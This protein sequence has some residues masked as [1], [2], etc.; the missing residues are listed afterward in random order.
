MNNN[1]DF[2]LFLRY[3]PDF[4]I[5]YKVILIFLFQLLIFISIMI[6]FWW[7]SS[8]YLLGA[9]LGEF[10]I[11]FPGTLPYR[12]MFKNSNSIR[13]K[14]LKKYDKLAGQAFWYHYES[15]T[16]PMISAAFYLPLLLKTDY[17]LPAII[18]LPAHV[19]TNTLFPAFVALPIGIFFVI[20]GFIIRSASK[21][22]GWDEDHYLYMI[23]PDEGKLI[24]EGIYQYI[25]HP[26]F[27]SRLIIGIGFGFIANNILAFGV[28][29]VHFF[30]FYTMLKSEDE[31]L[32]K[33]FGNDVIKFHRD[34]PGI[35]PRKGKIKKFI[36]Y[37]FEGDEN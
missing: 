35:I 7:I 18:N 14:Y 17:F 9:L 29:F 10:I 8:T 26:R 12:Y 16:I 11:V 23:Y 27:L 13:E 2:E 1:N 19:I 24:L 37:I 3:S 28:V 30:T 5:W 25:R 34:I 21:G 32:I 31:E 4:G 36:K 20:L 22:Y 6:F 15:Y 33:R